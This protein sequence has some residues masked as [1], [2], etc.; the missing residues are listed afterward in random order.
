VALAP[1]AVGAWVILTHVLLA[2]S[3]D[4]PAAERSLRKVLELEPRHAEAKHN[5]SVLLRQQGRPAEA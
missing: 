5:L 3:R 2:E 1:Q 4:W